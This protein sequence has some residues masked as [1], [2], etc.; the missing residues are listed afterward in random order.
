V[1]HRRNVTRTDREAALCPTGARAG[2]LG[3]TLSRA[4]AG[5][6]EIAGPMAHAWI[7]G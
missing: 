3:N 5:L 4:R 6:E 1:L 7:P 2:T